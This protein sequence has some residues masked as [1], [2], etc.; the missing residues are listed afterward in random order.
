MVGVAWGRVRE[1]MTG[2]EETPGHD[3]CVHCLD[4]MVIIW[5]YEL[6]KV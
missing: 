2:Q 4:L 1:R 6:I 5:L 3:E